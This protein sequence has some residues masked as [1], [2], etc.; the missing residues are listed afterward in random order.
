MLYSRPLA[1]LPFLK[2]SHKNRARSPSGH[3]TRLSDGQPSGGIG[4]SGTGFWHTCSG[5]GSPPPDEKP[6]YILTSRQ[7][8]YLEDVTS[9]AI[10]LH[11]NRY[12]SSPPPGHHSEDGAR[13]SPHASGLVVLSIEDDGRY[14]EL[15]DFIPCISAVAKFA[16]LLVVEKARRNQA[17]EVERL[18]KLVD[19]KV[20]ARGHAEIV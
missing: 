6:T 11:E 14:E 19:A 12:A 2:S 20:K 3:L 9:T 17:T 16:R 13:D 15:E 5:P 7:R 1:S 18:Q 10:E 8:E 4:I